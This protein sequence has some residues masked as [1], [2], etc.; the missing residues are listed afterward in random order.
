MAKFNKTIDIWALDDLQRARLPIGQWVS[1]GPWPDSARGRFFGQGR[2]TVVAWVE[3]ARTKRP[4]GYKAYM[5]SI[6]AYGR[7][8]RAAVDPAEVNMGYCELNFVPAYKTLQTDS[9]GEI[10]KQFDVAMWGAKEPPPPIG[11]EIFVTIN[12]C[13]PAIVTG[14][15]V[16]ENFLGLRC[17]LTNPPA[18]HVKQNNGNPNGH[19]FGPEFRML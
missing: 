15:F 1:A 6:A 3:N 17:R 11:A 2:S 13:G 16:L 10:I 14:Y 19:V 12:N 5:A 8:V 7:S 9:K 18:W 4:G